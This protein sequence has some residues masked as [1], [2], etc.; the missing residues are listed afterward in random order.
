MAVKIYCTRPE[1]YS[2]KVMMTYVYIDFSGKW[3]DYTVMADQSDDPPK[4]QPYYC[5]RLE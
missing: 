3:V 1:S 2:C 4:Q 5:K